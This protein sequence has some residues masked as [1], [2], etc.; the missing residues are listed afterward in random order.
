MPGYLDSPMYQ[1]MMA[2][3]LQGNG[4]GPQYPGQAMG[5]AGAQI[6]NALTMK[7]LMGQ[8]Q[9]REK[10]QNAQL[11]SLLMP[12]D[13]QVSGASP[14]TVKLPEF[15]PVK[16]DSWGFDP[17]GR[18]NR[19]TAANNQTMQFST[20][21]IGDQNES[22]R[23]AL[24]GLLDGGMVSPSDFGKH[25][26][27]QLGFGDEVEYD[28]TPRYDQNGNA[29]LTSKSGN[30]KYLD[31]V[32]SRDKKGVTSNNVVYDEYTGQEQGRLPDTHTPERA[33]QEEEIRR[34]GRPQMSVNVS[35]DR[36][37]GTQ[38]GENAGKILD[39]SHAAAAGGIQTI[40]TVAQI[41]SALET[42]KVTAGPGATAVQFFNQVAGGDPAKVVAT[43]Q[44]I[45]GL[46]QLTLAGRSA[47]KGQGQISDYEGRL[48]A[49]AS[50]GDIDSM[51]VKE[52]AAITDVADRNARI[53]IRLNK[54]NVEKAR[55]AAPGNQDLVDFYNVDEPPA[56]QAQQQPQGGAPVKITGDADYAK[57]PSGATFIGP[58]GKT[59]RKP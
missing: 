28:A 6:L 36:S 14:G 22:K 42:G 53:S 33:A 49:K 5:N 39:A 37:F 52:I 48:L 10:S 41:R 18:I 35:A 44:A 19:D 31:G 4:G 32:K 12:P 21:Q 11:A 13:V 54:G 1:R 51:T 23:Q 57:L 55:K 30:T 26:L 2:Q 16:T 8:Q 17:D 56:Y 40:N 29:F 9:D 45:Q 46:A 24:A 34:A 58:D 27:K 25:A 47:L 59:R 50:S 3:T 7:K 43:R 38:L 15:S 20:P